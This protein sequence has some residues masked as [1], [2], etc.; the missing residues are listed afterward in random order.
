LERSRTLVVKGK[1]EIAAY[2]LVGYKTQVDGNARHPG[3]SAQGA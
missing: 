3:A 2:R 1:G